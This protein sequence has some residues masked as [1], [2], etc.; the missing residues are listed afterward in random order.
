MIAA[1][2]GSKRPRDTIH[3]IRLFE[4]S[5]ELSQTEVDLKS[6]K[7]GVNLS[8]WRQLVRYSE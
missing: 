5:P 6:D 1:K 7:S 2:E 3:F 4:C 8:R